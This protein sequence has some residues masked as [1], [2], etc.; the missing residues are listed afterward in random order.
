MRTL[1]ADI[2]LVSVNC[3]APIYQANTRYPKWGHDCM[4]DHDQ[5]IALAKKTRSRADQR[6]CDPA[7][8]CLMQSIWISF[9]I[10][11]KVSKLANNCVTCRI[12]D[13]LCGTKAQWCRAAILTNAH[14]HFKLL[15]HSTQ[16]NHYGNPDFS[17]KE[18]YLYIYHSVAAIMIQTRMS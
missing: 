5:D 14:L 3:P 16:Q 6:W 9:G 7:R 13:P 8:L 15:C 10:V 17:L 2:F 4:N 1:N 18:A 11:N 12:T